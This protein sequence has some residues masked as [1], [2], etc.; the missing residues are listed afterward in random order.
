M[1]SVKEINIK[2]RMYYFLDDLIN[3]KNLDPNKINIEEK[4]YQIILSYYTEHM[5]TIL[6]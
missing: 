3:I 4:P 5:T 2:N 6:Q 1:N